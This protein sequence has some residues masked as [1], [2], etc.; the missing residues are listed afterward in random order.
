MSAK[1]PATKQ[2]WVDPDDAPELDEEFF[3][4]ADHKIGERP[5]SREEYAAAVKAATK[6]GRPKLERPKQS[7]TVRYDADVIEAFKATGPGWQ[8]RMNE[9]LRDWLRSHPGGSSQAR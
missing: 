4:K 6:L 1:S 5:V 3:R 9:A 8:T 7:V 2:P